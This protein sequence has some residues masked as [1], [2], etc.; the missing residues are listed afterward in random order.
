MRIEVSLSLSA[1]CG[2]VVALDSSSLDLT[3]SKSWTLTGRKA[4]QVSGCQSRG[5]LGGWLLPAIVSFLDSYK[6]FNSRDWT[7]SRCHVVVFEII[8]CH[9]SASW[10]PEEHSFVF[11]WN[12]MDEVLRN[13]CNNFRDFRA[14]SSP[15]LF[16]FLKSLNL[17][18]DT[19]WSTLK[20]TNIEF[21]L[22]RPSFYSWQ[23][24]LKQT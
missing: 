1:D 4:R 7:F 9:S 24:C 2:V 20:E 19:F 12:V 6:K 13:K 22:F 14:D 23:R 16:S 5:M 18:F 3:G 15:F 11:Y 21:N 8:H 10:R 17:Q